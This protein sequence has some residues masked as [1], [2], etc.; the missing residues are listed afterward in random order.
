MKAYEKLAKKDGIDRW[1][2]VAH[3]ITR[4]FDEDHDIPKEYI[5]AAAYKLYIEHANIKI[6]NFVE[7]KE[8]W[9]VLKV[10]G[11]GNC[12]L[13][14]C[15]VAK[16]IKES[17]EPNN[18]DHYKPFNACHVDYKQL[19]QEMK[20]LRN[21]MVKTFTN[22]FDQE[23]GVAN[24]QAFCINVLNIATNP[25]LTNDERLFKEAIVPEDVSDKDLE[26]LFVRVMDN[27]FLQNV[28][29][30]PA[31]EILSPEDKRQREI[32]LNMQENY[33]SYI[34]VPG[35]WNAEFEAHLVARIFKRPIVILT[36]FSNKKMPLNVVAGNHF[37]GETLKNPIFIRHSGNHYDCLL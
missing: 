31:S 29:K 1:D 36:G 24:L 9:D 3:A 20:D 34:A 4:L 37:L 14:S 19:Y 6:K 27:G 18:A 35:H 21:E 12:M 23:D 32:I 11:D 17:A 22:I 26:E 28:I 33:K 13:W 10:P 7:I 8:E 2:F 30:S 5:C 16:K 15:I 25:R